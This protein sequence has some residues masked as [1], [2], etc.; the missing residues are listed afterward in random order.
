MKHSLEHDSP[1]CRICGNATQNKKYL[2]REMLH[3]TREEFCYFQCN[4]CGCLQIESIPTDLPRHYPS[5]YQAYKNYHRKAK[6]LVRR[7]LDKRRVLH[8]LSRPNI[9][10]R[11]ISTFAPPL[12]YVHWCKQTGITLQSKI[13]DIGCG[14]GKLLSRMLAGGFRHLRGVDLFIQDDIVFSPE[15]IIR[16]TDLASFASSNK[17]R[18]DLVML[19]HS[20]EHMDNPIEILEL[21]KKLLS[22]DGW[23]LIRIPLADSQ[24]WEQY[25]ENWYALDAPRHL[26]LHTSTSMAIL[27]EKSGFV[28]VHEERDS[29]A[30]QFVQS[31]W[32]KRGIPANEPNRQKKNIFTA[33]QI[34]EF[35]ELSKQLN[36][37]GKGDQGAFYLKKRAT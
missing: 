4:A 14:N 25:R 28:I 15:A 13:L 1:S 26:Y 24:A 36:K 19:H 32:Y 37:T 9:L 17:E 10:G 11:F 12:D 27:A 16:K 3:G 7:F 31:E 5:D 20:F 6:S 18:F 33:K 8:E 34:R 23:L 22:D 35:D 2:V 29:G 30:S 21:C